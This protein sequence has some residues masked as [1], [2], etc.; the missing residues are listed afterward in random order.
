[1][2]PLSAQFGKAATLLHRT[3]RWARLGASA[4]SKQLVRRGGSSARPCK[5][6]GAPV[7]QEHPFAAAGTLALQWVLSLLQSRAGEHA[8][9]NT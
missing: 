3:S 6:P 8:G 7:A 5:P 1:M 4:R 9:S 2:L